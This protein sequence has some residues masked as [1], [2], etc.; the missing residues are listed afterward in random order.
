MLWLVFKGMLESSKLRRLKYT[1]IYMCIHVLFNTCKIIKGAMEGREILLL[2]QVG[3]V[4]PE[5]STPLCRT[6]PTHLCCL[7]HSGY[8]V[9][10]LLG[11]CLNV[12][13]GRP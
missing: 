3:M 2:H 9:S 4:A 1:H 7:F 6:W 11:V 13:V 5:I 12:P 8:A 10:Q